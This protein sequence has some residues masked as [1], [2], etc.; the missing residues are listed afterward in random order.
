ME[1]RPD[2]FDFQVPQWIKSVGGWMRDVADFVYAG[3]CPACRGV[4]NAGQELCPDCT[5]QINSL[6]AMPACF[7]CG[8]SLSYF[9][10]PCPHCVGRGAP[11]YERIIRLGKFDAPLRA[12]IHQFKYHHAW[13]LGEMLADRL[14]QEDH[15]ESLLVEA[16]CLL[17]V[18]LH[19]M[20]QMSRGFNQ[21][22]VIAARLSRK[23]GVP[24]AQATA[25]TRNTE[26]QTHFHTRARRM[27]NLKDAFKLTDE[28]EITGRHVVVVDDVLTTGA[29]LQMLARSLRP[30]KPASISALVIAVAEHKGG[31]ASA[32]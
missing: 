18:P 20:R 9:N 26:T 3:V 12:L 16:D 14:L 5:A 29:T 8:M 24:I 17:P 2:N 13:P 19:S 6:A 32:N 22:E 7:Q 31:M 11:H 28:S 25:R 15:V 27:S 4:C 1:W 10:A 30:A 23:T 21:A